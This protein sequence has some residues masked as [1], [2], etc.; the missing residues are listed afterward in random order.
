M[1]PLDAEVSRAMEEGI[2][3]GLA[4][5]RRLSHLPKL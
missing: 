3:D 4:Q 5:M 2:F 1:S